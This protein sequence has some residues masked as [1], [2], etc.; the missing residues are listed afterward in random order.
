MA[1]RPDNHPDSAP[2]EPTHDPE[3]IS[4][5]PAPGRESIED[6]PGTDGGTGGTG[7]TNHRV[8]RDITS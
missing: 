7:G 6:T 8:D 3:R 2:A 5:D 1:S 4:P